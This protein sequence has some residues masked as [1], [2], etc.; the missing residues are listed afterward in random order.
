MVSVP[1]WSIAA[2]QLSDR[3]QPSDRLPI[4]VYDLRYREAA[5]FGEHARVLG[6]TAH[7]VRT[8]VTDIWLSTLAPAWR[9]R[10]DAGVVMG[11]SG[12]DVL[13]C[14]EMMAHDHR[15]R[16]VYRAHH[17]VTVDGAT[18]H[19]PVLP[20]DALTAALPPTQ[21]GAVQA[22]RL[23]RQL[24]SSPKRSDAERCRATGLSAS[25]THAD[26]ISWVIAP[27]VMLDRAAG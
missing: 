1:G 15:H 23:L 21:W 9:R 8:D 3:Q 19:E 18:L 22:T 26:L 13:F 2:A 27:T 20:Q 17:R 12:F 16:V 6:L 4:V 5:R 11:L 25:L 14:L 24:E 10:P 7:A